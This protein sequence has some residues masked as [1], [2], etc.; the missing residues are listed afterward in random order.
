MK[1]RVLRHGALATDRKR[2][3]WKAE[4]VEVGGQK[5][6]ARSRWE[7]NYARYLQWEKESGTIQN[8]EHEPQTFWFEKI[9][10]GV[11]SYLPDFRVTMVDGNIE[12]HEVKGWMDARSKTK[13]K[14]MAKYY[15]EEVLKIIDG[16][17][18]KDANKKMPLIIKGWV[19]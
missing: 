15:P 16:S 1:T 3:S 14:R 2:G 10:R 4:W 7:A 5:F 17:W 11:R 9:K 12:W 19:S 6:F 8:W 18:F 13:I